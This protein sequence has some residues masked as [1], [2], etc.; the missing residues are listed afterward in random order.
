MTSLADTAYEKLRNQ[1]QLEDYYKILT[2]CTLTIVLVFNRKRIGEVQFLDIDTY[3][4]DF[5]HVCQEESLGSL[6]ELER[7]LSS[8]CKNLL[9]C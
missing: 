6:T 1:E 9:K 5:Q 8:T 7:T 2:E 3:E 4:R